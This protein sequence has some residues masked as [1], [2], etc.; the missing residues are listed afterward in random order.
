MTN[1]LLFP[2]RNFIV[3]IQV[4]NF[5]TTNGPEVTIGDNIYKICV[6]KNEWLKVYLYSKPVGVQRRP[7]TVIFSFTL[8]GSK[9]MKSDGL[10]KWFAND[11]DNCCFGQFLT[12]K[13]AKE[14]VSEDDKLLIQTSVRIIPVSFGSPFDDLPK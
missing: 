14:F 11:T 9:N 3:T 8:L 10:V 5:S 12:I 13:S 6:F 7:V 1:L 2:F 4:A